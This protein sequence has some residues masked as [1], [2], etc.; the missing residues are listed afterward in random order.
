[1]AVIYPK[2][3]QEPQTARTLLAMA[4][5]PMHVKTTT[6]NGF[7]FDV[8][9]YLYERYLKGGVGP[10]EGGESDVQ[11]PAD[12]IPRRRPGRPRKVQP[13]KEGD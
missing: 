8:P 6:D 5:D 11:P 13:A 12:E 10:D 7:A 4:D 9:E 2:H 1:M 3:G